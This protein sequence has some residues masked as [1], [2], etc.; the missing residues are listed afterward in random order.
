MKLDMFFRAKPGPS[1]VDALS[2]ELAG[3]QEALQGAE[4]SATAAQ[5]AL[6]EAPTDAKMTAV[7]KAEA[8]LDKATRLVADSPD[9]RPPCPVRRHSTRSAKYDFSAGRPEGPSGGRLQR[10]RAS[11]RREAGLRLGRPG[12]GAV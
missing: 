5:E 10:P 3:A 2:E 9:K 8:E 11:A 4:I 6:D 1:S 7:M 12:S